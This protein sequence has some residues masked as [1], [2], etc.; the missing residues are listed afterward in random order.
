MY[1]C[2]LSVFLELV[3]RLSLIFVMFFFH[4]PFHGSWLSNSTLSS[5]NL[6]KGPILSFMKGFNP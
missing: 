1:S 2:Y 3:I 4:Y 6:A 5:F